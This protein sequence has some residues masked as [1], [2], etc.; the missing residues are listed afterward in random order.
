M[1]PFMLLCVIWVFLHKGT[2]KDTTFYECYDFIATGQA[3]DYKAQME[4]RLAILLNPALEEVELPAM[5]SEQGPLMHMEVLEDPNGWTNSVV[6]QFYG[7]KRVV[8]VPRH[9]E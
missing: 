3:A 9:T 5:N 2:L 7:K 1:L 4:E 6:A 8:E